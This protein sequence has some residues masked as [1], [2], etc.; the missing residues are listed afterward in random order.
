MKQLF[1]ILFIAL[2]AIIITACNNTSNSRNDN[3]DSIKLTVN[4]FPERTKTSNIYEVNIRQYTSAG[5]F[6]AFEAEIPRLKQMGADI[7]WLMPIFPIGE[8]NRKGTKGSYYSVKNYLETNPD[9]GT[10]EDFEKM[11]QTAHSKGM[12]V[13]LDWVANHTSWDN[14]W[15][16]EHPDW[17]TKDKNGKII[18]PVPDWT[19]VA[20]LNYDK[21][22]MKKTMIDDMKYWVKNFDV[23]GFRCDVA[24][25]VP[26]TFWDSARTELDNV[27]PMF[28]LAEAEQTDLMQK[29]FDMTYTWN[30]HHLMNQIVQGKEKVTALNAYFEKETKDYKKSWYR[31]IFTSNHDENSWNGSEIERMGE[32]YKTWAAFTFVVP[33]MPLIYTGQEFCMKKRLRFFDKDTVSQQK[34][35]M[36]D[37]YPKLI[38]MKNENPALWNGDFGG[39][40]TILK[41]DK[42]ESVFAFTRIK[43]NSKVLAVFNFSKSEV[44]FQFKDFKFDT[45][46]IFSDQPLEIGKGKPLTLKAW[47]YRILTIK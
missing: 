14:N 28:M 4:K 42:P 45:K 37:L 18:S 44:K 22:E 40:M 10:K 46:D 36:T 19:D 21:K 35:E 31:M 29:A 3:K 17:Y 15:I 6:K 16:T 11:V 33:G 25:M 39:D 43:D 41:T 30:L 12:L 8:K 23:D 20:D 9:F 1:Y 2:P 27:K 38:K 7:L 47:E 5:T 32:S 34:C 26:S 13:I 24:M